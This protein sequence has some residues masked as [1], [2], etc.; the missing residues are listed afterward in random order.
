MSRP[1]TTQLGVV[2]SNRLRS[3]RGLLGTYP[4][5]GVDLHHGESAIDLDRSGDDVGQQLDLARSV[6][7]MSSGS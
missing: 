1:A 4:E 3:I 7:S 6:A 5:D 2:V